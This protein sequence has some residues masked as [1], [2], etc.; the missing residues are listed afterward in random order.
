MLDKQISVIFYLSSKWV[1]KQQR[2]LPMS[3]TSTTH[4]AQELLTNIQCSGSSRSSAK[5]MSLE[6]EK[7]CSQPSE[8]DNDQLRAI[9]EADPLRITWEVA[10]ELNID[11]STVIRH[12]KQIGRVK[13][14]DKW[15]PH[16]LLFWSVVFYS[17]QQQW[18]IS[19]SNCAV[20]WKVDFIQQLVI[21]SSVV[22]PR[23]SSKALPKTKLHQRKKKGMVTVWW[24]AAHMIHYSLL[25][26]SKPLYLRSMFSKSMRRT[27]NCNA[28]S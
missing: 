6:D 4:L 2:Q 15:L 22:G 17:I 5:E 9:I 10:E 12:L 7:H 23:R 20:W 18:N 1:V 11:L 25:N 19:W 21:T 26:P 28:C 16:E 27:K 3:T 14:F 24:S 8:T 13:K